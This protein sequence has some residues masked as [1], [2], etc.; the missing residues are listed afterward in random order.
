MNKL[1]FTINLNT[2]RVLKAL[3]AANNKIGELK[4]PIKMIPNPDLVLRL[5]ILVNQKILRR[6]KYFD[7]I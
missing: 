3:N 2:I 1:P 6:L 7:N 4:G 5:I